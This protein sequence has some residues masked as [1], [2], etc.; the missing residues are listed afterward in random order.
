MGALSP[1]G[2]PQLLYPAHA[3]E[4]VRANP[5]TADSA[6]G[7]TSRGLQTS[8]AETGFDLPIA[9]GTP[10]TDDERVDDP[11]RRHSQQHPEANPVYIA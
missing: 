6:L 10:P 2:G 8:E 3:F 7:A 9:L 4:G 1:G 5:L 11:A